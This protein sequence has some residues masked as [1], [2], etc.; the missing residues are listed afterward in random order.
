MIIREQEFTNQADEVLARMEKMAAADHQ[1]CVGTEYLLL[2]LATVEPCVARQ[3]LQAHR[4]LPGKV[5]DLIGELASVHP[6]GKHP[7]GKRPYSPRLQFILE[8]R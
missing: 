2:A 1:P 6:N 8:A 5:H 3:I 4:V 7:G